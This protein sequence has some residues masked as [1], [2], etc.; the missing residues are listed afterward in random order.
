VA[1]LYVGDPQSSLPRPPR[2][3][4]AFRK[5]FLR[6]GETKR[7]EIDLSPRDLAFYSDAARAWVVEAGEFTV[8]VGGSSRDLPLAGEFR[9]LKDRLLDVGRA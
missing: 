8:A 4:K 3:L 9:F 1:Q 6:P 5:V 2:E 7:V